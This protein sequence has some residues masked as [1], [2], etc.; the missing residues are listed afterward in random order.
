MSLIR[1]AFALATI[2][3]IVAGVV[4]TAAGVMIWWPSVF[5]I[6][7]VLWKLWHEWRVA[8]QIIRMQQRIDKVIAEEKK[9]SETRS[10][11]THPSNWTPDPDLPSALD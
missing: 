1:F 11:R 7:L 5:I 2:A 4:I 3:G 6:A 8:G 10:K 9:A